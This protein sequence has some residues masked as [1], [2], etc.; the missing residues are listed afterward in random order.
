[1]SQSENNEIIRA[2]G[3]QTQAE[4][5]AQVVDTPAEPIIDTPITP[6]DAPAQ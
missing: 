6:N 2:L 1:M 3:V 5:D 4:I